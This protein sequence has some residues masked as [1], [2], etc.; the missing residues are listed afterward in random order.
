MPRVCGLVLQNHE[1]DEGEGRINRIKL[2]NLALHAH[3]KTLQLIVV[4]QQH[5]TV[6]QTLKIGLNGRAVAR[7]GS[8]EKITARKRDRRRPGIP[9]KWPNLKWAKMAQNLPGWPAN[10][11]GGPK[12]PPCGPAA[13]KNG[14]IGPSAARFG[15]Q[16]MALTLTI[17]CSWV[18]FR[19]TLMFISLKFYPLLPLK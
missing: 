19:C 3:S 9:P 18:H 10:L 13:L 5:V 6:Q 16:T 11:P 8:Q 7:G 1:L 15:P 14:P 2:V 17:K 12:F 4:G